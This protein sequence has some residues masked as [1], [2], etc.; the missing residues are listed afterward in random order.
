MHRLPLLALVLSLS[1]GW[2]S[3]LVQATAQAL[4]LQSSTAAHQTVS[5]PPPADNPSTDSACSMDP[6]GGCLGG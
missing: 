2:W 3:P 4:G 5:P 6:W 1:T